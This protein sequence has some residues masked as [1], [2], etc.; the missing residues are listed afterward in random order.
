MSHAYNTCIISTAGTL[1]VLLT[2]AEFIMSDNYEFHPEN[3]VPAL[4]AA[5]GLVLFGLD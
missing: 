1:G 2:C 3:A 5:V 4:L